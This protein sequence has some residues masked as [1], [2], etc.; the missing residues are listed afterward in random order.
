MSALLQVPFLTELDS[1]AAVKGSRDPLGIQSIWTRFGRHVVGNLTTVTTSVLDFTTLLLG[2]WF[3]ER[4]A[5]KEGPGGEL[6]TFLKWEQLA[7]YARAKVNGDFA[8][9]GV[10]RVRR[11]LSEGGL[12]TLSD[13]PTY[14]ILSNQKIYGLWGLYT[15]AARTSDLLSGDLP[16]LTSP[17]QAFMERYYVPVLAEFGGRDARRIREV[18]SL[19]PAR[20]NLDGADAAMLGAV[21]KALRPALSDE[22]RA[23]YTFYLLYGGPRDATGGRQRQLAELLRDTLKDQAFAWSPTAVSQLA[24]VAVGN[25]RSW[26]D[27]AHY[28]RRI[29][30][31]EP[32]LAPASAVFT[33]LLGLDGKTSDFVSR[34]LRD[35]WGDGLRTVNA[36]AFAELTSEI[37]DGDGPTGERWTGIADALASGEYGRLVE[38]LL[39]QNAAVMS[40]R[41]GAP[42]IELRGGRLHVRFRDEEGGLPGRDE[43]PGLWRFP[44]FLNSVRSMA[45]DLEPT[46]RG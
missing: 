24:K 45:A 44:Y 46:G 42:W 31:S 2:Y 9:R 20:L 4:V 39:A 43:L 21:A 15:V 30:T 35:A 6:G 7:A 1:R 38:L 41:G 19:S 14:Q 36:V 17:A 33:H 40:Q 26:D 37:G 11:N 28:L 13:N 27:L 29:H 32:I 10:E 34:R 5:D 8:F 22:D 3:A 25:G 23:F 12:I 16:R 18:L